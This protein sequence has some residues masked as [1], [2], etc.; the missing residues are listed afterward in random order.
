MKIKSKFTKNLVAK[1]IEKAVSASAKVK[2]MIWFDEKDAITVSFDDENARVHLNF[3]VMIQ[4]SDLVKLLG[5]VGL[6]SL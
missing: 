1:A 2:P 4:K 5:K 6:G 3:D